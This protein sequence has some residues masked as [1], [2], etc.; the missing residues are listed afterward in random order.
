M[1]RFRAKVRALWMRLLGLGVS[2]SEIDTELEDHVAMHTE[3]GIRAGLSREDARRQALIQLGG[4]EQ[5]RQKYRD[6]RTLPWFE[7][8]LQDVRFGLRVM[9]R[10]RWYSA[11]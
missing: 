10:N 4:A 2:A 11:V 3:D 9:V 7:E 5:T 1:D 6:R 8:L